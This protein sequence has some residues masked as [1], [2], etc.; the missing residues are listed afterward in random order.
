MRVLTALYTTSV[1]QLDISYSKHRWGCISVWGEV[2]QLTDNVDFKAFL[3][4][5]RL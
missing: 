3:A 4:A 5:N 2:K 1:Q